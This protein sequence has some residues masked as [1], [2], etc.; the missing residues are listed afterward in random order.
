MADP[1]IFQAF[2]NRVGR[3][4]GQLDKNVFGGLLPGGAATPIGAALQNFALPKGVKPIPENTRRAASLIDAATGAIAR[5]Q[6]FVENTIKST[7][8]P[9]Q[10]VIASGLN[11]LP[12]SVNLFS[13][14]YTGLGNKNLQVPESVTTGIKPILDKA[15]QFKEQNVNEIK[16]MIQ[17][18]A[19]MLDDARQGKFKQVPGTFG[20]SVQGLNNNLAELKSTLNRIQQG[21]ISFNAYNTTDQNPLTSPATSLGRLWFQPN[22]GGYKAKE[23]YD[24]VYGAADANAQAGPTLGGGPDL[25]PTQDL[26]LGQMLREDY[27]PPGAN[28]N[29]LTDLGRVIV[30]KMPDKSF[31]YSIDIR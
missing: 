6:P 4:Y 12:F 13:R 18:T 25:T 27:R 19:Q 17:S 8:E 2:L 10:G 5:A 31:D 22:N 26:I 24:F 21:D 3:G 29:R 28:F 1:S 14:Y 7:P 23:K 9:V 15:T 11:V 20:F 16:S 30:G